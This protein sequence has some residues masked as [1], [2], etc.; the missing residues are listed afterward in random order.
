M[1][2]SNFIAAV[3]Q[4]SSGVVTAR[5]LDWMDDAAVA[6]T[7]RR[8]LA[9]LK[10]G[11]RWWKKLYADHLTSDF[12]EP[13]L[14]Y[15]TTSV[16]PEY[17]HDERF[18]PCPET[19]DL[20]V[21]AVLGRRQ[22]G[23][24]ACSMPTLGV[25]FDYYPG[26]APEK[27]VREYVR[28]TVQQLTP[29]EVARLLLPGEIVLESITVKHAGRA[30]EQQEAAL[31]TL[32]SVAEPVGDRLMRRRYSQAIARGGEVALLVARLREKANVLLLG[33]AGVGKT[34]V[35]A[36]AV[37]ELEREKI[38]AED[39]GDRFRQ[40]ARHRYW[41]TSGARLIAGMKYLGEWE[42][43]CEQVVT[44]LGEIDGVLCLE[45]LEGLLRAGGLDAGTG[46]AAFFA[47]FLERAEMRMVIEATPEQL[48]ACQRLLPG[49]AELFQVVEIEPMP[50]TTA[51][52]VLKQVADKLGRSGRI[53]AGEGVLETTYRLFGRFFP[54]QT[55]PGRTIP[56]LRELY[57]AA[58]RRKAA[59]V[60]VADAVARFTQQTGLPETLLRDDQPLAYDN[61][62]SA[63]AKS[64]IGQDEACR[65]A[66]GLVT[67][68]KAGMND[69]RRPLGVLLFCGPT[70]VGKTQL[71]RSLADYLFGHGEAKDRLVRL[72]M[73][74]YSGYG[75][76]QRIFTRPDGE[77]SKLI[78]TVR[79]QPF[80]LVLLD[81]IEKA[82]AEVFDVL[83]GLFDEGRLTDRFG[84][85]TNFT[86]S[87]VV[88]TSN[89]GGSDREAVGF[90]P[91]DASYE[92]EVETFF[93]PEFVNRID[94]L[95]VFHRLS[96]ETLRAI[97]EKELRELAKRE[98]LTKRA[99]RLTW[100]DAVVERLA[101]AGYDL[102]YG[103]RPLQRA[104]EQQIVAPLARWLVAHPRAAGELTLDLADGDLVV[105]GADGAG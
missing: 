4:D 25:S 47:P 34:A 97:A 14:T 52:D 105:R 90:S 59:E 89:L 20:R 60:T 56:F 3:W 51:R 32:R 54:Y 29:A 81:E 80:V 57:T 12:L 88:M 76:A 15:V 22:N 5:L 63:L 70:G 104:L 19:I 45:S 87:I 38:A 67:T 17:K 68:F 55:F 42:A 102:R 74:E 85:T 36:D 2:I 64:V 49:F 9:Q 50:P 83:L 71:A 99:L 37:R 35:L 82:A 27:L 91:G 16:R 75:A 21:A 8:A 7:P 58:A 101:A 78:Q 92:N 43:R 48:D 46:L 31:E 28:R 77:P 65:L 94:D 30:N 100:S 40:R 13:R 73:S 6:D 24:K 93:R 23:T 79:Q 103:A 53:A 11:L 86:S 72:D 98:G 95:V 18:Y 62:L 69:P 33:P 1:P 10:E 26:D 61:V 66:A 41:L 84:R 96:Q 44:E 39:D